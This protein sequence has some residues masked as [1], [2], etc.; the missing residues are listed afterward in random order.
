[1]LLCIYSLSSV[2]SGDGAEGR[3][4]RIEVERVGCKNRG[5]M[6]G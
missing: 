1:M 6:I 5:W 3:E 2:K 4:K